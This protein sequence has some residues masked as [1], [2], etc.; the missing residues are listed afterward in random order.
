VEEGQ[1][2][3]LVI[4]LLNPVMRALLRSPLHGLASRQFL[5]LTITGRRTGR[6][7]TIPVGRHGSGGTLVV[8]AAGGWRANLRGGAP[9][10]VTLG[11][12][13][14]AG[15]ATLEEDPDRVAQA[16]RTR[17]QELGLRDAR[18]LGLKVNVDRLPTVE[19]IKPAVAGRAIAT[20]RL[21]DT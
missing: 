4:R 5:L 2:P 9:V 13:E 18:Q 14:R 7:Y 21:D 1:P 12:R 16:Y 17:L 10:R 6:T 20:I 11:G 8:Y 15:F 19:E 3:R